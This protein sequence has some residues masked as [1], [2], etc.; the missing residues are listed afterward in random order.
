MVL[1]PEHDS[2][3]GSLAVRHNLSN[4]VFQALVK[5]TVE[6]FH[7]KLEELKNVCERGDP[8]AF[9]VLRYDVLYVFV[10]LLVFFVC[11]S[12]VCIL[13]FPLTGST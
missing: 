7:V 12:C 3:M 2:A 9:I 6:F 4:P 10:L 1:R 5:G 13:V 11:F 8:E